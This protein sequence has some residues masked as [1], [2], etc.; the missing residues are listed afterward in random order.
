MIAK[1]P[2]QFLNN[3]FGV[4]NQRSRLLFV[5][6]RSE[7]LGVFAQVAN[8]ISSQTPRRAYARGAS[9]S[10]HATVATVATG[11]I[12]VWIVSATG[13]RQSRRAVSGLELLWRKLRSLA[14]AE[15]CVLTPQEWDGDAEA[16]ADWIDRNSAPYARVFFTG[17]SYGGGVYFLRL[18]KAL[19][20]QGMGIETAVL[21]DAVRRFKFLKFLSWSIFRR[22]FLLSV[23]ANVET[24]YAFHQRADS[25]LQGHDVCADD[26]DCTA[27]HMVELPGYDHCSIDESGSYH[28][29]ATKEAKDVIHATLGDGAHAREVTK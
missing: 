19:D 16:M 24:V 4:I 28:R 11:P 25:L 7:R 17:Y 23:P 10:G 27:V 9:A 29:V 6:S 5:G 15:V 13:F 21:C 2:T 26:P 12:K 22:W 20:A 3:L 14:S 1:A 18:A 8:F